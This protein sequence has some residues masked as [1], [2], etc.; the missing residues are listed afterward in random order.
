M[1]DMEWSC[2]KTNNEIEVYFGP[3]LKGK[4]ELLQE[5]FCHICAHAGAT[6]E[7]CSWHHSIYGL[8][9]IYAMGRYVSYPTKA[10]ED[11]LS[12]HIRGFK[13]WK[14]YAKPLGK[15]LELT[16]EALYKEL[17]KSTMLVPIPLH[18]DKLKERDYNQSLEL[19]CVVGDS[20]KIPVK[21]VMLKTRNIDMRALNWEERMD[22]V[23]GLYSL[24]EDAQKQ[25]H[26]QKVLIIDD[27]VTT[28]FTMSACASLLNNAGAVS[29]N[30]LVAGR[31][32]I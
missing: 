23:D 24:K 20:L 7:N 15:G 13:K 21:E 25:I 30:A 26:G 6:A 14:N 3:F 2:R 17:L 12:Y 22:A 27:V 18:P 4:Y 28:G 19:A 1:T 29:V 11:L 8:E 9:R 10:E 32:V 16:I 5:P 31:A